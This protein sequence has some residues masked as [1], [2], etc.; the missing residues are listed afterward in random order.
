M[1]DFFTM[2]RSV[3]ALAAI[4]LGA[5][6]VRRRD[7]WIDCGPEASPQHLRCAAR[8][9]QERTGVAVRLHAGGLQ[10]EPGGGPAVEAYMQRARAAVR[11]WPPRRS[12]WR[13]A[14]VLAIVGPPTPHDWAVC[15]PVYITLL[16]ILST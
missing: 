15:E 2:S 14:A 3:R 9:L 10:C 6:R 1:F 13:R 12:R 5:R 8:A 16:D 11:T 7:D 4:L